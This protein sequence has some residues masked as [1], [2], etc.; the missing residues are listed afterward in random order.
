MTDRE[1]MVL[2]TILWFLLGMIFYIAGAI[3]DKILK[4]KISMTKKDYIETFIIGSFLGPIMIL[5]IIKS[6]I[7]TFQ[8]IKKQ[9]GRNGK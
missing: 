2:G 1:R 4:L 3:G 9:K 8:I 6:L 7:D 5:V